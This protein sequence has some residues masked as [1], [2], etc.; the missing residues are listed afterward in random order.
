[1]GRVRFHRRLHVAHLG[2]YYFNQS[3]EV[4]GKGAES[5][6]P[7]PVDHEITDSCGHFRMRDTY[8]AKAAADPANDPVAAKAISVH[9]QR[10]NDTLRGLEKEH[11][12]AEPLQLQELVKIRRARLSPAAFAGRTQRHSGLLHT[13]RDKSGLRTKTRCAIPS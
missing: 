9:F 4:H 6:S 8:L 3:G 7:R 11:A 1:M 2:Q 13:L 12:A 10:V 5:G